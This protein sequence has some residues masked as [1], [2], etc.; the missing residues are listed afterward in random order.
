DS[1]RYLDT[2]EERV[3][4]DQTG[5]QW[6]LRSSAA[7]GDRVMPDIRWRTLTAAMLSHQQSG[8]PVHRWPLA[9]SKGSKDW[10]QSYQTV[11]QF[12]ST[13]LFTVQPDDLMDLV[14]SVM[15]WRHVRHVPVEDDEGRLLGLVSHRDLLRLLARGLA[16][17]NAEPVAVRHI[18]KPN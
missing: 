18:M 12:M 13:D 3:R 6:M 15:D 17:N 4:R 5:A 10:R 7:I 14:A 9:E 1:D 2:I 8:E 11:G 16:M